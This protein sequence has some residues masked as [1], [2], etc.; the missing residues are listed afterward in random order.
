MEKILLGYLADVSV[1]SLMLAVVAAALVGSVRGL[2]SPSLSHSIWSFVMGGMLL[3]PALVTVLPVFT[4]R[5]LRPQWPDPLSQG[6]GSS[7][8]HFIALLAYA[9]VAAFLV[10]RVIVGV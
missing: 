1:R 5:I 2:R 6:M 8:W 7:D 10:L 4:L 9:A 3:L